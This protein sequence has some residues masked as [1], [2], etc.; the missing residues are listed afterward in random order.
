MAAARAA[1]AT[2]DELHARAYAGEFV[3]A[4]ALDLRV[5]LA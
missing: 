3:P 1:G 5:P 4:A 2:P